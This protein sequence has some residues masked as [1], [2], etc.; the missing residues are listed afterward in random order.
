MNVIYTRNM[1]KKELNW[2]KKGLSVTVQKGAKALWSVRKAKKGL[3]VDSTDNNSRQTSMN[4]TR[5]HGEF[6]F[7]IAHAHNGSR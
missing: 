5:R 3:P 6:E 2:K 1:S 4:K 7:E